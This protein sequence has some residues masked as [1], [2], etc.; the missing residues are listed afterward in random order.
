MGPDGSRALDSAAP[1][2][3]VPVIAT[4][5][6]P[7]ECQGALVTAATSSTAQKW[8]MVGVLNAAMAPPSP[9]PDSAVSVITTNC[10]PV[11]AAADEP[12]MM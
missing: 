4:A 10:R 8:M 9:R 7:S 1:R 11:S 2:M 6:P 12:T 5:G 3:P